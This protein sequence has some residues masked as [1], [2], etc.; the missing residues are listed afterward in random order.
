MHPDKTTDRAKEITCFRCGKKGHYAADCYS[1]LHQCVYAQRV[2]EPDEND[3]DSA[4]DREPSEE[5]G[6]VAGEC[7]D[8]IE[9]SSDDE[10]LFGEQYES[11]DERGS[12][13]GTSEQSDEYGPQINLA[14]MRFAAMHVED[15]T[16]EDTSDLEF[17]SDDM[18]PLTC[19]DH[20]IAEEVD[21]VQR[22]K[23]L[24]DDFIRVTPYSEGEV[25]VEV[26]T[27]RVAAAYAWTVSRTRLFEGFLD[28]LAGLSLH[29]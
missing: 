1:K 26:N 16:T 3:T 21:K 24:D 20:M 15:E 18:P 2:E 14:T 13:T 11:E 12:V 8:E 28:H 4:P 6:N 19:M 10:P 5:D 17:D 25:L 22:A 27:H 29:C 9:Q 23:T 7:T